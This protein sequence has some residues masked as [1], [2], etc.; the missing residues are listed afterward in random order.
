MTAQILTQD[1]LK[2]L[3]HYDPDT[4][5]FTRLRTKK[6]TGTVN[7]QGYVNLFVN[8][9]T[10]QAHRAAYLYMTGRLPQKGVDHVNGIRA[11]NRWENLRAVDQFQNQKNM[12]R[13]TKNKTGVVGVHWCK[14]E[15]KWVARVCVLAKWRSLG[16]YDDFFEAACARKSAELKHGYHPNHGRPR[17][18]QRGIILIKP[19][20]SEYSEMEREQNA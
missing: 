6:I 2:E 7:G 10:E 5:V 4:G 13:S 1:R 9:K 15:V 16:Y 3:L 17:I 20:D 8:G 18:D 12:Q 19:R 14:R 11:D